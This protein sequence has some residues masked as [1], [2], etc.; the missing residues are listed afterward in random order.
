MTIEIEPINALWFGIC[1]SIG[2]AI[3]AF[4][5]G[6]VSEWWKKRRGEEIPF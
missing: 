1:W 2:T 5:V 4:I 6:F 3:G